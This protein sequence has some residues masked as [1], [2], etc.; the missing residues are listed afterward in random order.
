VLANAFRYGLISVRIRLI[1]EDRGPTR[2][3]VVGNIP[4]ATT[5]IVSSKK[6]FL[7]A[8]PPDS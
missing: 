1:F 2:L 8:K 5:I 3:I 7:N 4:N 6:T